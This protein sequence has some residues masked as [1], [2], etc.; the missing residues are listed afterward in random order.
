VLLAFEEAEREAEEENRVR[1]TSFVII[2]GGATGVE[3]SGAL[4]ELSRTVLARDFRAI[5]PALAKVRLI[6]AGPRILSAF[7]EQLSRSAVEQL[8]QLGVEVRLESKVKTIDEQGITLE[9]GERI[10]AAVVLWAAGVRATRLTET[11]G[12]ELDRMRRVKVKSDC[13]IPGHAE[14]FCIGD[15]ARFETPKGDVLPG[16]SPVAM[17]QAR[18]VAK[19]IKREVRANMR[20]DAAPERPAFEYFDKG[21][22]ATIG[23][24][25]AI[26]QAAGMRLTGFIAWLAWLFIHLIYLVGF[27][28]RLVVLLTWFWSYLWYK[29]GARLITDHRGTQPRALPGV[30]AP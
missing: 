24:S 17:Q 9:S 21:S 25:R 23:R 15:A 29:R 18:M 4:A 13:S 12:V 19:I 30:P 6:E 1:L 22:M 5:N 26:A 8:E 7:D 14:A 27:K 28:N 3:L 2:G 10:P 20:G 11:L 16:L